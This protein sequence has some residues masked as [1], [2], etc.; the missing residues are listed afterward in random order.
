MSTVLQATQASPTI[1]IACHKV[2]GSLALRVEGI[3]FDLALGLDFPF[4]RCAATNDSP[5][6]RSLYACLRH[7][8][9]KS[10]F[11]YCSLRHQ[12]Q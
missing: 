4:V 7:M 8:L 1:K 2:V 11:P 10:Q 9:L 3:A 6:S 5:F 12:K